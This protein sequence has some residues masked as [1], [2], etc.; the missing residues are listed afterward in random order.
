MPLRYEKH[1]V[2]EDGWTEWFVPAV[3]YKMRCCDCGLVHEVGLRVKRGE[4]QMRAR[5]NERATAT[6]RARK[7]YK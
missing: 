2:D 6:S 5:R 3:G 7:V 1:E 4:I